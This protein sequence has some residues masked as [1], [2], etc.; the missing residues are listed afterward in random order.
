M[1]S[2][3]EINKFYSKKRVFIT[4]HTGFVGS[5]M[6]LWLSHVGAEVTGYSLDPPS[7]PYLY[8]M[9]DFENKIVNIK[10][11][12]R[13]FK[14]LKKAIDDADP[15][16]IIHLAAQPILLESYKIP[17]ETY[18]TN[19]MGTVNL[20]EAALKSDAKSVINVT[21]DKCYQN[22][23]QKSGYRENDKLGGHDPY[24]SSKACSELVTGAYYD[25]FFKQAGIGIASA[26]A[27]NIIGGG[28]W[29]LGRLIPDIA[30]SLSSNKKIIVRN[31]AAI[32]PWQYVLDAIYGYL[33]LARMVY[34]DRSYSGAWNFGPHQNSIKTVAQLIEIFCESWDGQYSD[35]RKIRIKKGKTHEDEIL[36]LDSTKT[37]S[38]LG[39]N[40]YTEFNNAVELTARWYKLYYY[41]KLGMGDY[42]ISMLKS[43]IYATN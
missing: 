27:G 40:T 1:A 5:W 4:G 35:K 15:E 18:E 31:P 25:S 24:S 12:V 33:L 41:S 14:K 7:K 6:S 16:I 39:W 2:F 9:L 3:K 36:I 22:T 34:S 30:K 42:S 11:D 37:R 26:R 43:Y 28:D 21:S 10:G 29:G 20:L 32:R 8:S 17:R 13:D 38:R 23:G 19:V